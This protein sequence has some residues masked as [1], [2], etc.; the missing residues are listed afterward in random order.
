[1][2]PITIADLQ[3]S[4]DD[5]K[6]NYANR[7]KEYMVKTE[8]TDKEFVAEELDAWETIHYD[9][10]LM[11]VKEN[12]PWF[13]L[14]TEEL[15]IL[16]EAI[17]I[18]GLNKMYYSAK[19]KLEF[20]EQQKEPKNDGLSISPKSPESFPK[21]ENSVDVPHTGK[22]EPIVV[23]KK[24]PTKPKYLLRSICIAI[25]CMGVTVDSPDGMKLLRKHTGNSSP[26]GLKNNVVSKA[27]EITSIAENPHEDKWRK[28]YIDQAK[29]LL[30]AEKNQKAIEAI[31]KYQEAFQANLDSH[32]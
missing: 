31:T 1:M 32:Q 5:Y 29:R 25:Y 22:R 19:R 10:H 3:E 8:A 16:S 26:P 28:K 11:K 6:R 12:N 9:L 23:A 30:I 17:R 21:P 20:L 7:R 4:S 27:S 15:E 13:H 18:E 24:K 14:E 2:R